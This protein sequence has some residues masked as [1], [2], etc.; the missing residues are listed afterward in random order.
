ML[1]VNDKGVIAGIDPNY[2]EAIK[3]NFTTAIHNPEKI[4]PPFYL[5]SE[6]I[7]ID[8]KIILYVYVPESSQVHHCNGKIYDRNQDGD[9][10]IT[11]NNTLSSAMYL[12]KQSS[13][14]ENKIYPYA[15]LADL[16][17]DIIT[18][19][20]TLAMIQREDHPWAG[21]NDL[22]LLKSAQLYKK[23]YQT[24]RNGV[25]LAGILLFGKDET[26]L[27]VLP[28]FKTD[29]ILRRDNIDRYDDRDDIRTNLIESYD[30]LIHFG[31]KHLNDPFYLEN[32]QRISL[33]SHILREVV[34][35]L[36]IHREYANPFPAKFIID[37]E[38]FYTENSNKSHGSGLIDPTHFSPYPKNPTI[39][40]IFKE[41]GR[42][43]ELGSG[44]RNLFRYCK[45]YCGHDPQLIESE[46]F[47]FVLLLT[48]Q[49]SPQVTPQVT[50]QV[51]STERVLI[52]CSTP[53]T[54]MEIQEFLGL[55][56][57]ENFR[58]NILNPLIEQGLLR[59]TIPDKLTS[60]KQKYYTVKDKDS[61]HE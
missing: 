44:V 26:I 25:T 14:S 45:A 57:R 53:K 1:G 37:R 13:Y 55:K 39:A 51:E 54:R 58:L 24:G 41:I 6:E 36:L 35:N 56:D 8:G 59:P 3:K 5:V 47:K 27:S 10:N 2:I 34:G 32:S 40:R 46:I 42:A 38:K 12:R 29:A 19:V 20:R 33:R 48:P 61:Y 60:P 31:E 30:R 4:N 16:R 49:V 15:E 18:R 50:V 17:S 11:N 9:F 52:F 23:D 21:M 28:H 7:V 22:E 43:D